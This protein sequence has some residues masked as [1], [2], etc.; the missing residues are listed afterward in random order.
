MNSHFW[1]RICNKGKYIIKKLLIT[2]ILV[3]GIIRTKLLSVLDDFRE[4]LIESAVGLVVEFH[5]V[6]EDG[7]FV[8]VCGNGS[9]AEFVGTTHHF[10]EFPTAQLEVDLGI[11]F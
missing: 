5:F 10:E 8:G 1:I 11:G 9:G 2:T 3:I 6:V 7:V 4:K